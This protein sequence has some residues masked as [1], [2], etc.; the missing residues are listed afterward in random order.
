[1][2]QIAKQILK[3]NAKTFYFAGLLLDKTTLNDAAILYAFCRQLDDAADHINDANY[4]NKLENII[5][6]FNQNESDN[7]INIAFK[8][9]Q[10]KYDLNNIFIQDLIKGVASDIQ[11]KQPENLKELIN[12][13]YQV[14]GTVGGL[15]SKIISANH[16]SAWKFAIDLG[17]AMQ[18]TN[19]SRDIIE[20]AKMNRIYIPKDMM[21]H[22]MNCKDI[23]NTEN[24]DEVFGYAKQLIKLAENYYQSGMSGIYF[25]PS[26]KRFAILVAANLYQAI[27]TKILNTNSVSKRIYLSKFEKII[28]MIKLFFQQKQFYLT[29]EP[30]HNTQDLHQ[31]YLN[32]S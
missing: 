14:A 18:L 7:E 9:I 12:Y 28:K 5:N 10:K 15:M 8:K 20:D 11:F 13:C 3:K 24:H 26:E 23:L 22:N 17:I 1:M 2:D 27:G 21:K 4:Q 25:I 16:P 30:D 31:P 6:D 19:I 29:S 32:F